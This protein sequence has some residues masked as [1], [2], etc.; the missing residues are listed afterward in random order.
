MLAVWSAAR[1]SEDSLWCSKFRL[2]CRLQQRQACLRLC[3]A[4]RPLHVLLHRTKGYSS[5]DS[6]EQCPATRQATKL[7][8]DLALRA[9][10]E[11]SSLCAKRHTDSF[12]RQRKGGYSAPELERVRGR[13]WQGVTEREMGASWRL[14]A[15][16]ICL[17]YASLICS[18]QSTDDLTAA[19]LAIKVAQYAAQYAAQPPA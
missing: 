3:S 10:A 5:A 7:Q 6:A 9:R 15:L 18:A 16:L 19:L 13:F 2:P 11:S 17:L 4:A 12:T 14:L 1:V 8:L